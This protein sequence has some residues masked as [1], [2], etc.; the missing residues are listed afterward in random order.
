MS[1]DEKK[2]TKKMSKKKMHKIFMQLVKYKVAQT[3]IWY[4]G[5]KNI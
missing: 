5:F 4:D 1:E 3:D 2:K